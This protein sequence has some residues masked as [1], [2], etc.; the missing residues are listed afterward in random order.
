[1][2]VVRCWYTCSTVGR[3]LL[4]VASTLLVAPAMVSKPFDQ[5]AILVADV[6]PPEPNPV[7]LVVEALPQV[8]V[9]PSLEVCWSLKV[10]LQSVPQ[11]THAADA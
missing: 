6:L 9:M 3:S 5:T 2:P 1:M 4:A 11:T 8:V 10:L 7:G